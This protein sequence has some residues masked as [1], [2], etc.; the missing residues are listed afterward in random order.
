MTRRVLNLLT[1]L[2]LVLCGASAAAYAV[3]GPSF[4]PTHFTA[5]GRLWAVGLVDRDLKVLSLN[6]WPNDQKP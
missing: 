6:N 4:R 3:A 1:V 5:A 2:S